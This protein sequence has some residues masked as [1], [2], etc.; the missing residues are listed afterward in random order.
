MLLDNTGGVRLE[1]N[2]PEGRFVLIDILLEHVQQRF[3]LLGADVDTLKILDV[4]AI[5]SGLIDTPEQQQEVP[6][7]HPHL[8]AI[9]VIFAVVGSGG[10][11][12]LGSRLLGCH[13]LQGSIAG[14]LKNLYDF[15]TTVAMK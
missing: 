1:T 12:D 11:L 7:I 9:G 15:G 4:Y 2:F 13:S 3:G 8:H 5:G 6:E 14:T 10:E